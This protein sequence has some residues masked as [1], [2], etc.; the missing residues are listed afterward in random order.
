[1]FVRRGGHHNHLSP[2]H[3]LATA[4]A[5]GLGPARPALVRRQRGAGVAKKTM[6]TSLGEGGWV[7]MVC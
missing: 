3:W 6:Q 2:R 4:A 1:M 7:K 5:R